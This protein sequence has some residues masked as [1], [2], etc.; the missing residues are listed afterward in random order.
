MGNPV[1]WLRELIGSAIR[2]RVAGPDQEA[3]VK[4]I[5]GAD[6]ERWHSPG[7][8]IWTVNRDAGVPSGEARI[9][10]PQRR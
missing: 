5:W 1:E 4:R 7:D 2:D 10:A 6:G 9:A 3:R 8:A